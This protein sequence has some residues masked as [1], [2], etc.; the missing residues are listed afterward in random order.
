MR[1]PLVRPGVEPVYHLY[2]IRHPERDRLR[3]KLSDEGIPTGVYYPTPLHLQPCYRSLGYREGE[4]PV[5]EHA[6]REVLA[7]PMYPE[8]TSAQVQRVVKFLSRSGRKR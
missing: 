1:V 6:A 7:L 8:M 2:V 4:C 5:A 3:K